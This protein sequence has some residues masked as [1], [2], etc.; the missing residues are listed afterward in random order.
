MEKIKEIT[1]QKKYEIIWVALMLAITGFMFFWIGQKDGFHEDEIFTYGSSNYKWD[2][3]FQAV[4]KSDYINATIEKYVITDDLG[5]TWQNIVHYV[6]HPDEF[7]E[8]SNEVRSEE[9]LV[10]KTKE[11]AK[12]YV[13]IGEG[14]VWNYLSVYYHQARDVHPPLFYALVHLVSSIAYG[15]FSKYIIFAINLVFMLL[16]CNSIRKIFQLWNKKWLGLLAVALYGFSMG[17]ATTAIFLRM[18]AMLTFFTVEYL[19]FNIKLLKNNFTMT[20]KDKWQLFFIVLLGFLTQYYFC[21]FAIFVFIMMC[22]YGFRKKA[23]KQMKSYILTH[24]ITAIVGV[25]L[26]PPSIYHIFLS[27]RGAGAGDSGKGL[28]EVIWFYIQRLQE[29]FSIQNLTMYGI[30]LLVTIGCIV[31][32]VSKIKNKQIKNI[33]SYLLMVIPTILYFI[34]V[35]KLA[36]T[37]VGE[38][39][40][41]RY[42]MNILPMFAMI[43]VLAIG[44]LFKER[45]I[46][47]VMASVIV[48]AISINGIIVNKPTYLYKGYD[49]YTQIAKQYSHLPFVYTADNSFT[50]I[51]SIP[52]FMI[53]DKTLIIDMSYNQDLTFLKDDEV[54][55][56]TN[57]FVLSIKKWTNVEEVLLKILENTGFTSYELLYN[58]PDETQS[59]IYLLTR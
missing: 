11:E 44:S 40:A 36:P 35:A 4:G 52:E 48:V 43:F 3:V 24:I 38:K 21:L 7:N 30:V 34:I 25:I 59:V 47:Y 28:I 32:L 14:D 26:F 29:A 13:T 56:N 37:N 9:K 10:W 12:D 49:Q 2:S 58:E 41:I 23:Y 8:L 1:K 6:T 16:T 42:I 18:Y 53:Y 15:T 46:M 51:N 27:Y 45:R 31:Q 22:L 19:Y 5:K 50:P 33:Q 57:Q 39:P 55:Q 54:L 20:K 17:A